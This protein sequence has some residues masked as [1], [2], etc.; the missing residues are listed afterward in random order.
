MPYIGSS[1]PAYDFETLTPA[2]LR[3][4]WVFEAYGEFRDFLTQDRWFGMLGI[5]AIPNH[6]YR[7]QRFDLVHLETE[8]S[9]AGFWG[10]PSPGYETV[11]AVCRGKTFL[12][13][14]DAAFGPGLHR[15][16]AQ[17]FPTPQPLRTPRR[18]RRPC[19]VDSLGGRSI[20]LTPRRPPN[21]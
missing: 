2:Y 9:R 15:Y 13:F 11:V 19:R 6:A 12:N 20:D 14:D 3:R 1:I 18:R 16:L 10:Q 8:G 5:T 17:R 21:E 4:R 7:H